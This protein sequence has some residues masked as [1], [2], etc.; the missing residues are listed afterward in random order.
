MRDVN[1]GWLIRYLHANGASIFFIM[2][3]LH[4]YRNESSDNNT[5]ITLVG[6]MLFIAMMA[7]AFMGYILPWGQ[8]SF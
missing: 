4:I 6:V 1:E 7:T 8:M 5:L 2:V 3:Y